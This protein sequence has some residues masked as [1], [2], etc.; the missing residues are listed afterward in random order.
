[1]SDRI[2][3][4]VL[5]CEDDPQHQLVRSYL[6]KCGLN[7]KEPSLIPRVASR[8]V[9]GGNVDWVIREFSRE[10]TACM[11]RHVRARTLL[12]VVVDADDF[13]I[14]QRRE[15]L[16]ASDTAPAEDMLVVLIPKRH[17]ETWIRSALGN[18][19]NEKDNYKRPAP[20]KSEIKEAAGRIHGWAHNEPE[21]GQ[22]CVDSLRSSLPE[23]R[24]I[25]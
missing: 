22:E 10:L 17:I 24:R 8:E 13:T 23:W 15:H 7:A 14:S 21:P 25:C 9:H 5:L 4:T 1:M 20:K 3:R 6:K 18:E 19:V 16:V 12:I 11:Q 2:S